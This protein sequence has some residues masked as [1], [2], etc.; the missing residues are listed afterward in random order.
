MNTHHCKRLESSAPPPP[1]GEKH[2]PSNSGMSSGN[3]LREAELTGLAGEPSKMCTLSAWGGGGPRPPPSLV[4]MQGS[5][6]KG[7]QSCKPLYVIGEESWLVWLDGKVGSSTWRVTA[8]YDDV[9]ARDGTRILAH[10]VGF[11]GPKG[12]MDGHSQGIG[13]LPAGPRYWAKIPSFAESLI[14]SLD[15]HLISRGSIR[16][17]VL[18]R[19]PSPCLTLTGTVR[20]LI[21]GSG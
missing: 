2:P 16:R 19:R 18:C 7:R 12:S 10:Q 21:L 17:N 15:V 11:R 9:H 8:R 14:S 13:P 3:R 20:P 5:F 6:W 1:A 4:A